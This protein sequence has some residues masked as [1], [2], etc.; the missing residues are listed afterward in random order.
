LKAIFAVGSNLKE[1]EF[2]KG[3]F[4][5]FDIA[6]HSLTQKGITLRLIDM[7]HGGYKHTIV[8]GSIL[9]PQHSIGV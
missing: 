2:E 9:Q 8:F 3:G 4:S 1:L 5:D 7:P 6:E